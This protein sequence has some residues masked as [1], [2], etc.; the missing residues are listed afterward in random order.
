[1]YWPSI[2]TSPTQPGPRYPCLP[3]HVWLLPVLL[4]PRASFLCLPIPPCLSCT[5]SLCPRAIY[6]LEYRSCSD[7]SAQPSVTAP[8]PSHPAQSC[9]PGF[10]GG[11][12]LIWSRP[13]GSPSEDPQVMT[14]QMTSTARGILTT[15][16]RAVNDAVMNPGLS[17]TLCDLK[18]KAQFP[19]VIFPRTKGTQ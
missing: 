18:R 7:L 5:H 11:G 2:S 19:S 8:A 15:V 13:Y 3:F 4:L 17:T 1:M 14:S 9:L 6:P 10:G 12:S 16:S